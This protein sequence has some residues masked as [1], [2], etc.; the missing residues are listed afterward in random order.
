M[1]SHQREFSFRDPCRNSAEGH[2]WVQRLRLCTPNA[3]GPH[4]ATKTQAQ[5]NK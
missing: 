2:P 5:L 1:L 3:R 4:A